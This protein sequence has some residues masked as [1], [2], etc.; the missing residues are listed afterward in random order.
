[1]IHI[2]VL[3]KYKNAWW[4]KFINNYYLVKDKDT[5]FEIIYFSDEFGNYCGDKHQESNILKE[6]CQVL[7]K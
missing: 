2:K 3:S 6:C 1:M 7:Q 5:S 4:N